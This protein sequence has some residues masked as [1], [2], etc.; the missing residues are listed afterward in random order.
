M[1]IPQQGLEPGVLPESQNYFFA[2]PLTERECELFY[3]IPW[4]GHFY[5]T[6]QY[7]HQREQYPYC[8][9]IYVVQGKFHFEYRNQSFDALPGDVVLMDLSEP[10]SY[11]AHDGLEF[12]YMHFSGANSND[13]CRYYL[14]KSEP[15]LHTKKNLL[16]KNFLRNTLAFY[17]M[18][19]YES[20]ID[21]SMR[22]YKCIQLLFANEDVYAFKNS[23]A[24][25]QI[26]LYIHDHLNEKLTLQVLADLVHLSPYYLSRLFKKETGLSPI[27]YIINVR[28]N[29]AKLLLITTDQSISEIAL[30]V[31]YASGISFTNV[32]TNKIGCAPKQFRRLMR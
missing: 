15:L 26:L 31:G 29:E 6:D 22:V 11:S 14:S 27:D 32:F 18:N 5:C 13:L 20:I 7:H 1:R 9:L 2:S 8:L 12:M 25:E 19:K 24:V 21:T 3:Y 30:E 16:I 4:C 28:M 17:E 10:H 23:E